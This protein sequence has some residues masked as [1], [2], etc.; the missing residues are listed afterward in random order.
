MIVSVEQELLLMRDEPLVCVLDGVYLMMHNGYGS[1]AF[2][3]AS[4]QMNDGTGF[5]AVA[6]ASLR[7]GRRIGHAAF[8]GAFLQSSDGLVAP[9]G[10]FLWRSDELELG[11]SGEASLQ[12]NNEVGVLWPDDFDKCPQKIDLVGRGVLVAVVT[13]GVVMEL[14]VIDVDGDDYEPVVPDS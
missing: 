1:V 4:L 3:G 10:A 7:M 13:A 9:D 14:N 6:A 12:K 5:V 11:A 8:D 2:A